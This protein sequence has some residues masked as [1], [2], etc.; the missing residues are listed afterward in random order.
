M[1]IELKICGNATISDII[2]LSKLDVDYIGIVT[3]PI[4]PRFVKRE[5]L[6]IVK[7]YTNKP[8]VSV[9]VN[10]DIS[11][12]LKDLSVIEY[13]QIHR[14][15]TDSEL[16]LLRSYD[17]R[18]LIL[19][20][21]ASLEYKSYLRKAIN[22]TEKILIDSIKKGIEIDINVVKEIF[23]DYPNLG[24]GGKI[25]LNNISNFIG[26]N[27]KWI[28]ISSS[29]EIYPGKKSIEKVKKIIE[30]IKYGNIHDK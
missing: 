25:N 16:E 5:F 24:V 12:M 7:K 23:K 22:I 2:E 27:P 14:I 18:R 19:Y 26:L 20:V 13:V 10:G 17:T 28:D 29:V 4:S 21:P 15:L 11:E 3:D 1:A 9:K 6:S 8:I 30:V